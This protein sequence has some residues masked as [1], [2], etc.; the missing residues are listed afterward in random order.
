M[1]FTPINLI[2]QFCIAAQ[3]KS[4]LR[5]SVVGIRKNFPTAACL[6]RQAVAFPSLSI[7]SCPRASQ[8]L[9]TELRHWTESNCCAIWKS[10]SFRDGCWV[11]L[12]CS[13]ACRSVDLKLKKNFEDLGGFFF[14][15]SFFAY[16]HSTV[17][18]LL[19][20][21]SGHISINMFLISAAL[22]SIV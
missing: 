15:F 22:C 5:C 4:V 14:F 6:L 16:L 1:D 9:Q 3:A 10:P 20:E 8:R 7:P 2:L 13:R 12:G 11:L 18:S 17:R 19:I 21:S